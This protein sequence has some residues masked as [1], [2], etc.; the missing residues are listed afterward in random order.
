MEKLDSIGFQWRVAAPVTG[1]DNRYHQLLDYAKAH[2]GDVNVPQYYPADKAFGRWVMKQRS[3]Y[4]LRL[5]GLK[6][7]LT[8]ERVDKLNAIGFSWVAPNF[9]RKVGVGIAPGSPAAV[10]AA[11]QHVN[12]NASVAAPMVGGVPVPAGDMAKLP[13]MVVHDGTAAAAPDPT[14]PH[15]SHVQPSHPGAPVVAAAAQAQPQIMVD[16]AN[17][18]YQALHDPHHAHHLNPSAIHNNSQEQQQAQQS[19]GQAHNPLLDQQHHHAQ[20]QQQAEM[21]DQDHVVNMEFL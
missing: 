7:Q 18:S 16:A 14:Q 8:E 3:E 6:S 20:Q 4:S 19:Q 10:A 13:P 2:N 15:Y 9:K 5:R 17:E 12:N 11:M 1:W 21:A